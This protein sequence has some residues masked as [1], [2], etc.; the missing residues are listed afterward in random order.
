MLKTWAIKIIALTG[1]PTS[2]LAKA[3][4]LVLDVGVEKEACPNNLAPTTSTTAQLVM[5]DTIA[6][7]LLA[8][9]DFLIWI[10]LVFIQAGHLVKDYL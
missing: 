6:I 4:D 8:C 10:L 1:N 9:K 7:S 2:F 5:G 3:S